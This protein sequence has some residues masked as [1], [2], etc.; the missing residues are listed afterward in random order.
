MNRKKGSKNKVI[1]RKVLQGIAKTDGFKAS[2]EVE[3]VFSV[4]PYKL[5]LKSLGRIFKSE[6]ET[7]E[8]ALRKIK[9]SGGA[10][11]MCVLKVEKGEQVKERILN[12]SYCQKTFTEVGPTMKDYAIRKVIE[13]IGL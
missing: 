8:E 6:G 2:A 12:A 3:L 5:T 10:K 11:A 7:L 4:E 13:L 1:T 9:I